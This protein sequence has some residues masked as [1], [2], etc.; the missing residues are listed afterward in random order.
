MN[1]IQG[2]LLPIVFSLITAQCSDQKRKRIQI[3]LLVCL[4]TNIIKIFALR[5]T[6]HS[7]NHFLPD[8]DFTQQRLKAR[9]VGITSVHIAVAIILLAILFIPSG[10]KLS[11]SEKKVGIVI[12]ILILKVDI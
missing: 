10:K 4:V 2:V 9:P 8:T 5:L 11:A 3:D 12:F 6:L 7:L 1:E